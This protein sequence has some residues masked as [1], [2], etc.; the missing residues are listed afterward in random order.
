MSICLA[1][2]PFLNFSSS[3]LISTTS[4]W[5]YSAF[6]FEHYLS[7]LWLDLVQSVI[8]FLVFGNGRI[9]IRIAFSL[10]NGF[11][12]FINRKV[13][14]QAYKQRSKW[15][16]IF[17]TLNI[18][19]ISRIQF[20]EDIRSQTNLVFSTNQPLRFIYCPCSEQRT[21]TV[22]VPLSTLR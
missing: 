15:R 9:L 5:L 10:F 18:S 2:G 7:K 13:F 1:P 4:L 12:I 21:I 14:H 19:E 22:T 16:I 3:A 20:P 6:S 11:N 8:S 17:T